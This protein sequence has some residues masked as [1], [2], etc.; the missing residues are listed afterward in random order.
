VKREFNWGRVLYWAVVVA[1]VAFCLLPILW[2]VRTSLA[3]AFDTSLVPSRLT[4]EHYVKIVSRGLLY[5]YALNSLLVTLGAL[6]LVLPLALAAGYALARHQFWGR[7]LAPVMLALPLLPAVT[8]LVPIARYLNMVGLYNTRT[9]LILANAA[10][11]LPFATWMVWN[12]VHAIP[13]SLEEAAFLDGCSRVGALVRVVL[14]SMIPGAIAAGVFVAVQA[15]S[16]Y[17]FAF[18]LTRDAEI[19]VLPHA[20]VEFIGSWTTDWGGLMAIGV[21]TL[22]PPLIVFQILQRWFVAGMYGVTD[23]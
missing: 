16:N 1:L 6:V 22:L 11:C 17:L 23:R 9:A 10:F 14:P 19:R 13:P 2:G 12:F 8:F 18:A 20:I 4:G 21:L 15:W 3:P 7:R 5:R